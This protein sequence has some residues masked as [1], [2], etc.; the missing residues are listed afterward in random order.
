MNRITLIAI[1]ILFTALAIFV[2]VC[3]QCC[4]AEPLLKGHIEHCDKLPPVERSL[5]TGATVDITALKRLEP[6]NFWYRV[7]NWAGGDWHTETNEV[8][9][10]YDYR[11]KDKI[12][13]NKTIK[14]KATESIGWQ[15][16]ALDNTWEFAYHDYV[17]VAECDR[18]YSVHL[19]KSAELVSTNES[20]YTMHYVG[21]TLHVAMTSGRILST[22]QVEAIQTYSEQ[23][24][25]IEKCLAS[26][27]NFDQ[28]GNPVSL[29]KNLAFKVKVKPYRQMNSYKGRDMRKLFA[30]YLLN[31]ELAY[32]LP[33]AIFK[34]V[35]ASCPK[36]MQKSTH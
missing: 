1:S 34:P 24:P 4:N 36:Q 16:D 6:D 13:P 15:K 25:G 32:L 26:I 10:Y 8:Y 14:A 9:F 17:T 7:P 23:Q 11:T 12:F 27:K 3:P 19:V 21:T 30:E 2:I 31:H 22:T 20:E 35:T 5:R 18:Y 28:E 33:F 29:Q